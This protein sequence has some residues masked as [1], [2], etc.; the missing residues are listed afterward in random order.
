MNNFKYNLKLDIFDYSGR[1]I[2]PLYD[3]SLDVDGQATNVVI[4]TSRNGWKELSFTLP[5]VCVNEVNDT[6][7]GDTPTENY[8]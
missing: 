8:R 7:S 2:C 5:S 1:K 6:N 4:S 3:S